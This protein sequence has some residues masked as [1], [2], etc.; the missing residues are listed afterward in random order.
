MDFGANKTLVEVIK[1]GAFEGT[2]FREILSGF[3][4]KLH[5]KSYKK[6]FELKNIDQSYFC[7][8]LL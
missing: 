6:F 5:G 1:D 8:I 3:N 4:G 2:Y 7:S